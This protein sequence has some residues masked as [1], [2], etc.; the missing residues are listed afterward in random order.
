M[1]SNVQ[2]SWNKPAKVIISENN[3]FCQCLTSIYVLSF[4]AKHSIYRIRA[5]TRELKHTGSFFISLPERSNFCSVE[6]TGLLQCR[7]TKTHIRYKMQSGTIVIR[8]RVTGAS[9]SKKKDSVFP[10]SQWDCK[11]V[12]R[13]LFETLLKAPRGSPASSHPKF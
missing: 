2:F 9:R 12:F 7:V 10:D 8:Y 11:F 6:R 1:W 13:N 3:N 4:P 5:V